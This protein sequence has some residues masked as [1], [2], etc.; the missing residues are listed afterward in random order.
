V[1]QN[2]SDLI[3]KGVIPRGMIVSLA[4]P[5]QMD[6]QY[7]DAFIKG[8]GDTAVKYGIKYI[9]GDLNEA[10]DLIIDIT[11]IGFHETV[12]IPRK[13]IVPGNIVATTGPFGYTTAGLYLV[14]KEIESKKEANYKPLVDSVLKPT[15]A[16][17]TI[18]HVAHQPGVIASIDSSDGLS[19]SLHDLMDVN[20]TGFTIDSLPLDPV[21][22]TFSEEFGIPISDL[23]FFGGEEYHAIFIIDTNAW[24]KIKQFANKSGYYLEKIGKATDTRKIVYKRKNGEEKEILKRGFEHFNFP[25]P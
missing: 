18:L 9:G 25:I 11:M 5:G 22:E 21:I 13:G 15:L 19:A 6:V 1:I 20:D 8:I 17:D 2:A 7:F 14:L 23:L 10:D 16:Y 3:V 4:L 24:Q 12:L